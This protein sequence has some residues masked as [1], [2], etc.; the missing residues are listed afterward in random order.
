MPQADPLRTCSRRYC[1]P[2]CQTK[3]GCQQTSDYS[4]GDHPKT[5]SET[6]PHRAQEADN[7]E[8]SRSRKQS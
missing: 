3:D 7:I 1:K 6:A 8:C 2:I 4:C 5:K